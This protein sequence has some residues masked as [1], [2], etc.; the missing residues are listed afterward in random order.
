MG[1]MDV[2]Y[3]LGTG[4]G[5]KKVQSQILLDCTSE[6]SDST[7]RGEKRTK[8]K[9]I[10]GQITLIFSASETPSASIYLPDSCAW[11]TR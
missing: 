9:E 10:K 2:G 3:S 11:H 1:A 4:W 7:C 6:Y 8:E 5:I